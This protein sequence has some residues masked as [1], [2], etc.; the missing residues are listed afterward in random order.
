M[1][2]PKIE[3]KLA[4]ERFS[5]LK[6]GETVSYSEMRAV[7]AMDPQGN[8]YGVISTARRQAQDQGIIIAVV[9]KQGYQRLDPSATVG[10]AAGY[11]GKIRRVSKAGFKKLTAIGDDYARLTPEEKVRHNTLA[12][13]FAMV[14]QVTTEK[15]VRKVQAACAD[16][17]LPLAQTLDMFRKIERP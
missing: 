3:T 8:G 1:I 5:K 14:G 15:S 2:A 10:L 11:T 6:E 12:S 13:V 9:P 16:G 4:L 7:I 17:A